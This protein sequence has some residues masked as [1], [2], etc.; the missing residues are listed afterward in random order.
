MCLRHN[1]SRLPP[2]I[3]RGTHSEVNICYLASLLIGLCWKRRMQVNRS[4]RSFSLVV[5]VLVLL[6]LAL[7]GCVPVAEGPA[8]DT[9]NRRLSNNL[10]L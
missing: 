3:P 5:T 1:A 9:A 8:A 7:T 6:S 2:R 4:A 10:L